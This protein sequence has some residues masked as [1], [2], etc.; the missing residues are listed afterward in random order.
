MKR[1]ETSFLLVCGTILLVLGLGGVS[2]CYLVPDAGL[3]VALAVVVPAI[4]LLL[5]GIVVAFRLVVARR[6]EQIT[7]RA[8]AI[9]ESDASVLTDAV[10]VSGR[11][12]IATLAEAFNRMT[13]R[14]AA[15]RREIAAHSEELERR[16]AQ[17]TE[18]LQKANENLRQEVQ[19]R[20]RIE[21]HLR[22]SE[23]R[24]GQ[25]VSF[26]PDATFVVDRSGVVIAW[27]RAMEHLTGCPADEVVGGGDHAYAIPVYGE[28][29]PMLIDVALGDTD[30]EVLY[31]SLERDGDTVTSEVEYGRPGGDTA[32]LWC[33]AAPL[34]DSRGEIVG[35]IESARDVTGVKRA[36]DA[37]RR[38]ENEK[39]AILDATPEFVV[40][41]DTE[42]R[43]VWT[44]ASAAESAGMR[45]EDLVG[46]RCWEFW[47]QGGKPCAGCSVAKALETG[48]VHEHEQTTPDGR[49]WFVR[50]TPLFGPDGR[51]TGAV[52][53]A[54]DITEAKRAEQALRDSEARYRLLAENQH[55]VVIAF[56]PDGW[57]TYCSPAVK[58]FSGY[59]PEEEVGE[60]IT[61]YIATEE[62]RRRVRGVVTQAVCAGEP[63]TVEFLF[64]PND[65][66]PF[67]VEASGKPVVEG[68]EVVSMQAV[69]RDVTDRKRA[70]ERFRVLFESSRDALMTLAPLSWRFTSGNPAAVAMFGVED[71]EAFT[72]LGPWEVSPET[73]PDG[74]P[75]DEKAREMIET[76]VREGSHFFEWTHR[77]VDGAP[78]PATVLLTRI[79]VGGQVML[80][81]TVRDISDRKRAEEA[82]AQRSEEL[83]HSN[84]ELQEFA[85]VA[86]HDLQEPLRMVSSY[87]G[88]LARRY[89]DALDDDAREFIGYAVDGANRMQAL[90]NDLLQ[91]SRV[92]TK[93]KPFA[94]TD[95]EEVLDDVLANLE[96]AV[97][98]AGARVTHDPLPRVIA[99]RSQLARVFQNLISNALKFCE[100]P[101]AIHVSAE[102]TDGQWRF[103]V[104]DN[105]IGIEPDQQEQVFVV[106]H[107]LHGRKE[108][109]GTGMGLAITKK[110]VERH[111]GR[112]WVE[113]EPGEGSTFRFT[114]PERK[115]SSDEHEHGPG[116]EAP[117]AVAC[118]AG[119]DSFG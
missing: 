98:E 68:G 53:M 67:P 32:V 95:C 15:Q 85:Y 57:L 49:A 33:K 42:Q 70:E 41:H 77:Q 106:F 25:I 90:I 119:R 4:V 76:A 46:H 5:V 88:L 101:P 20:R 92:G 115:E 10:A 23:E 35:A 74:R 44:N 13:A 64:Q 61:K 56:S 54:R 55:D 94:L 17:R 107:R 117:R 14:L 116:D 103:S 7:D 104:R 118:A 102:K 21:I 43:I 19:A 83:Q 34:R 86:S 24:L 62:D 99:D 50:G 28:R 87:V 72:A 12:E 82:L 108:Y 31:G 29:R 3:P 78:F 1:V 97:K 63:A 6:L 11:D 113:S 51:V 16:V 60:P 2:L 18:E 66:E 65:G 8:R 80:Q 27:N 59:D 81:A 30:A 114:V 110:I 38:S 89:E 22:D 40:L 109:P 93:G 84:A 73:Q 9:A 52:E 79:E 100:G 37:L 91:Y 48:R 26:L 39:R 36:E 58:E 75:S 112:I 105:G 111:G 69:L 71:E 47:G 96:V 45:R